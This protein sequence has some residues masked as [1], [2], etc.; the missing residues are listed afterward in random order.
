VSQKADEFFVLAKDEQRLEH[1][2]TALAKVNTAL[3]LQEKPQYLDTKVDILISKNRVYE[4][5]LVLERLIN[6]SPKNAEYRYQSATMA[7]NQDDLPKAEKRLK[8]ALD[9]EPNNV[10]YQVGLANMLYRQDKLPQAKQQ[11]EAILKKD[12]NCKLAWEQYATS[13]TNAGRYSDAIAVLKRA[14]QQF[15][16]DS[17]LYYILGCA[18]DHQGNRQ[19]AVVSYRRSLELEPMTNSIAAS[20]IFEITGKHVPPELE[21]MTANQVSFDSENNLMYVSATINGHT[22]RFLLDTGASM[23]VLYQR[24]VP[25]Y[26]LALSPYRAAVET[27]NG[28]IQVPIGYGDISLGRHS[29]SKVVFGVISDSTDKRTDGIIGMNFMGKFQMDIDKNAQHI[30]LIREQ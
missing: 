23:C 17:D 24:S 3:S 22:G 29:L 6:L 9:I 2:E 1:W 16:K 5:D 8:E 11:Y 4:A 25:K 19:Q 13:H 27:A 20:R 28:M 14:L 18:Y 12:P 15:P 26:Q 7:L 21:R 30:T 10:D